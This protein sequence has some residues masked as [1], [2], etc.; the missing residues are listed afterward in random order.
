MRVGFTSLGTFSRT[1]ANIVGESPSEHRRRGPL[2]A[3]A[4]C[5]LMAWQRP[6]TST[7]PTAS[8]SI[9]EKRP[10]PPAS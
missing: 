9:S 3:T 1:F 2:P 8:S 10:T 5:F 6:A 4:G 7:H